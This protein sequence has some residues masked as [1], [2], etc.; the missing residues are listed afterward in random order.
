[1]EDII[2][3]VF[4]VETSKAVGFRKMEPTGPAGVRYGLYLP[5]K[6]E[7]LITYGQLVDIVETQIINSPLFP[8]KISFININ[9]GDYK[10]I[11]KTL[12]AGY[13]QEFPLAKCCRITCSASFIF[14]VGV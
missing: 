10:N 2:L 6:G 8:W 13:L 12:L 9:D 1:M 4:P 14:G 5:A 7:T 11:S 3:H